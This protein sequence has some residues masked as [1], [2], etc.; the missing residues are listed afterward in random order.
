MR[1]ILNADGSKTVYDGPNYTDHYR[2]FKVYPSF[3]HD[4]KWQLNASPTPELKTERPGIVPVAARD[5][6]NLAAVLDY[7]ID[8]SGY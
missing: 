3:D 2:G 6:A 1:H 8:K 5:M 7:Q 4:G